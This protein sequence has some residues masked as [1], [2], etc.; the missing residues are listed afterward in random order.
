MKKK[1]IYTFLFAAVI[2]AFFS[3]NDPVF[4]IIAQEEKQLE[5]LIGGSP[6]NFVFFNDEM[7]VASGTQVWRYKRTNPETASRAD[8]ASSRPGGRILQIAATSSRLYALS[9]EGE[10]IKLR[11]RLYNS[12]IWEEIKVITKDEENNDVEHVLQS[13]Y[14]AGERL[15]I[16][17]G[18]IGLLYIIVYDGTGFSEL[19]DSFGNRL[20][21]ESRMLN[22]AVYNGSHYYL[23]TKS[24]ISESDGGI[25]IFDSA[26]AFIEDN[27]DIPFV[28]IINLNETTI[29]AITR[30][31]VLY[32]VAPNFNRTG[33]TMNNRL[34]TGALAIW[35]NKDNPSQKLLLAGRQDEMKNSVNYAHGYVELELDA[36]G[37]KP[38]VN[39]REP[40][41]EA[42]ESIPE[43]SSIN[44][45][46]NR[47][48]EATIRKHP[49]NH[50]FQAPYIVDSNMVLFASTQ[51]NGV[52][53]YR[54]RHSGWHW[55]AE[56]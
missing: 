8:W 37:L 33:Y 47:R 55:N 18:E 26:L 21:T 51:T 40:G 43:F 24:L 22:G 2:F 30:T 42:R 49:V 52:W 39:F 31:G 56:D 15:F 53:S 48:Y 14:T 34:A 41:G 6:T 25:Y 10:T 9:E 1:V 38:G 45:G 44:V 28:G 35:T 16:N 3:C 20:I 29:V 5:P 11:S 23:S 13:I 50:I 54:D 36:G 46:D 17:A 4:Y 7:Y 12:L 27:G 19:K 32:E